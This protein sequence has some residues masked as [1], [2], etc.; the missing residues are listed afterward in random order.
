MKKIILSVFV[1]IVLFII[2]LFFGNPIS[3]FLVNN[4]A[5]KYIEENYGN[6]NLER[7]KTFYNFKDGYYNIRL[8]DKDSID[9]KF[10]L[11]YDS[12]GRLKFD[13]FDDR[14]F[15]TFLRFED[16]IRNYG[17]SLEKE[18]NFDYKISLSILDSD[19][20]RDG[21]KLDEKVDLKNFPLKV[22]AGVFGFSNNLTLEE[23][24][25]ILQELQKILDKES[26]EISNYSII[27][28]PTEDKNEN[29]EAITWQNSLSVSDI[30]PEIIRNG[31]INKLKDLYK[32]QTA[33]TKN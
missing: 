5:D 9:T 21:L 19:N 23:E 16:E 3:K 4:S 29:G 8:Q 22:S 11:S 10:V 27:L 6:L 28:I 7:D 31:D 13:N 33:T 14:L 18:N 24:M 2:N 12:F 32:M 30:S 25:K 1:V 20:P 17:K 15:N 26:F